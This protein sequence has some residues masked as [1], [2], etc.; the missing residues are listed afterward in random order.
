[1]YFNRKNAEQKNWRMIKKGKHFL[2]GCSLVFAVGASLATQ[3][4][5]AD[6]ASEST[7]ESGSK[8]KE[9][10]PGY[11]GET[12]TYEAPAAVA[13]TQP[14]TVEKAVVA[15]NTTAKTAN[16]EVLTQLVEEVKGLDKAGKTEDSLSRLN[17]ALE[18]AQKVLD[19]E[20]ASQDQVDTAVASLKE[21][22]AQL[23]IKEE[24]TTA[25]ATEA[26]V[27]EVTEA[28]TEPVAPAEPV[29]S[30]G[31]RD[32]SSRAVY[33][34][35][36]GSLAE[37]EFAGAGVKQFQSVRYSVDGDT[38]T[39]TISVVPQHKNHQAAGLV[40]ASDDTIQ[41]ITVVDRGPNAGRLN[42]DYYVEKDFGKLPAMSNHKAL[43]SHYKYIGGG[44]PDS[45]TYSVVTK[46]TK[47]NLFA[48]FATAIV[49]NSL[50]N[51]GMNGSSAVKNRTSDFPE[52][53]INISS[54]LAPQP[55]VNNTYTQTNDTITVPTVASTDTTISGT[56]KPGAIINL[57]SNGKTAKQTQVAQ[58]GQW[59]FPL[60]FGLNSSVSGGPQLVTGDN[61][62]VTQT[63][64]GVESAATPVNISLGHSEIVPSS[65]S[66]Q[67]N[68]LV[69]NDRNVT[70]KV[71]HDAG[72]AYFQFTDTDG[73]AQ[74]VGLKRTAVPGKWQVNSSSSA[75][76]SVASSEDG[77][78]YSTINLTLN[79]DMKAGTTARVISNMQE[80]SYSSLQG[81]QTRNV[82][83]APKAET[84]KEETPAPV[85]PQPE[86]S[87]PTAPAVDAAT[88]TSGPEIVN[89]LAGKASTPADVTVKAP[90]GSTVKLYNKDGV[91]IGEAVANDQGV[92]T[93]HPTNSL[94]EGEIT[95][96]TTPAGGSESAKSAPITV[97][98]TPTPIEN[99]QVTTG[100][101][102]LQ[103]ITNATKVTLYRGD[104][105]HLT[106]DAAGTA[107]RWFG[108]TKPTAFNV[109]G[110]SP[111]GGLAT[112]G[113]KAIRNSH[114][115]T[116]GTVSWNQRLG[117]TTVTF[118]AEGS[119][120]PTSNQRA[121]IERTI[122]VTVLETTKK[123]DPVAGT[124]VDIANPNNVSEDEKNK[125]I[126][127][128]KTANPNLP[129]E[130]QY[131]VDEKG[132][133][134]ITYPDGS[135]DKVAAAYLVN[136][137]T[138]ARENVAPTVEI[139]YSNKAEKEV[140]VY[141]GEANSFD[142]KFK[143]DSGKIASATVKQGGNKAFADVAG[144]ANTINTQYGFKANVINAETPAT[145]DAPAVIT[146]SGTPA[147]T[148]GLSKERLDAATKGENPE[149]LALGWRYATAT[150]TDGAFI[151]N[152]ATNASNPTDPGAFRVMLKAQ[153]Q[154]YDIVAP[155]EKV[156]VAD[157]TNVTDDDLA[158]IKEKLQLE[159]SQTN[160]D[161]NL[162]DKKG[163]AVADKDAK[164]QSVTKD[165]DGNL[166]VTYKDGSQDKKP[167]SEFVTKDTTTPA[168]DN[169]APTVEIPYSNKATKEV[170]VYGG[171]ANSFDIKFKDDSGKIASATVKQGGNKAFADV[172][173][174]ANTINTQYG[175]K[176]NVINAETPATADA[177]A[178][179]T[180]SGT[181]AAT[182][183]LSKER[184]DA[185]T[186]GENPEGL[187]LGWRYAT[188]TDTDGAF[189]ENGAT[190]ASN[191]TDPGAFRVMLKAQTQK[192]DIV[193]PT[194]KVAVADPTN[195]TD[196]DLAKIKEKLQ[197]EY[198]Q[199]NDDANLA[200][201]KGTAV[202]DKD[203]KIQSVTKDA[204]G[205]LVVTY[206]DGSQD[207]KPLSEFV[208]VAPTVELPYSN[209][210][211]KEI[212]VYTGENTDLTFKASDNTA[213]KDM[214]VRGPGG[215]GKDNTADYGFTTGKI[216]NSAVTHGDGTVSG[217][218]AT[219]KMTGVTTLK[220]PNHWTS[221]V[222]AND[223]DNA[224]STTDFRALDQNPNAT[225]TPG[226]VHFIVKS[227]TDKYDI[228]TPAPADK[229]EVADPDKVTDAELDKIKEKLQL[230]YKKDNDDANIAKDTPVDK[231]GK[232]KSVT[233]DDKGNLVVTYT[234]GST[235][236]K[237]LSEFVTKKPTDA[238]KNEPT[239]KAQTVDKGTE[240]KAEDSIGNLKDLPKGTTV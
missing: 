199:T 18:Q 226:Y 17:T 209:E 3:T 108:I 71:P 151:E 98:K 176:A 128:V 130:T 41:S 217:A 220:A 189:I 13:E 229:V 148:D 39:W 123:Y 122:T 121:A 202:A 79:K 117:D 72:A 56:G 129:A 70:L 69:E 62:S 133:L 54:R 233:K 219:I 12:G 1:M 7:V 178:V 88:A 119:P 64:G 75:I 156:A 105:L 23:A 100:P 215:I 179:I 201:K 36:D 74:E 135:T 55:G 193:A 81:W 78:F 94:P 181:P 168:R 73:K 125:I 21:A 138:P 236:T 177:P 124:K 63:V 115:E 238:D 203:A 160:D 111:T 163:T 127:S 192:Y 134:T 16:K 149:G 166:V 35:V 77:K 232:I 104:K 169:V 164:I 172:A 14:A 82:E 80:G 37:G 132:N 143:D 43:A 29:R 216:E 118:R 50:E 212:Y 145:A 5:H 67:Q 24:K 92:A 61:I 114:A 213:V 185:A 59:S 20:E 173:G 93:V 153:T 208:N 194:E 40:V 137:T 154:K 197:L 234:D 26:K 95:A 155:T 33:R 10:K 183:G 38:T 205:N 11:G 30:R 167:L 136:P 103:M 28:A 225:Q 96:T 102:K 175:F 65:K 200:D 206:A 19:K 99:K 146:Y 51:G 101:Y 158:K 44:V 162:A 190:N 4:V 165:A 235:D 86:P 214:Y 107:L 223:N 109:K 218:T 147:A 174:E 171:E 141:G 76:A 31:K 161:A 239:P 97:T 152:G 68:N 237:P 53:G 112:N 221:F 57:K 182:D 83:E 66:K 184:L 227:Q 157:P 188:A 210:A 120:D 27:E 46:G 15:E 228:A 142:I 106:G 89:D 84:P 116:E 110:V 22:V 60:D 49:K 85:A 240:P 6:T 45:L 231:D 180:Y 131:S 126:D 52:V 25:V 230:E 207:K 91:V 90:A 113:S 198:S 8:A 211:K 159:Y 139:P 42:E 32:L 196:D 204:D 150:D 186:K 48:R 2:F 191:P 195:V 34:S 58:N 170:Y 224:P 144:E 47:H 222:V 87:K 140:Y 187:A 9:A